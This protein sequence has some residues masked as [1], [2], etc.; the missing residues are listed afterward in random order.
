MDAITRLKMFIALIFANNLA[1]S[2]IAGQHSFMPHGLN[3][4]DAATDGNVIFGRLGS[5]RKLHIFWPETEINSP[6]LRNMAAGKC[7]CHTT[8]GLQNGLSP[9]FADLA[10]G[11][12]H[13]W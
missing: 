2:S 13:C 4:R 8:F 5:V 12:I 1:K 10:G 7:D 6:T 11:E 9:G 3:D